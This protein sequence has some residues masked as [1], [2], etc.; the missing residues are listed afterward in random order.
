MSDHTETIESIPQDKI[1]QALTELE[2]HIENL[3]EIDLDGD[4]HIDLW[5]FQQAVRSPQARAVP[6]QSEIRRAFDFTANGRDSIDRQHISTALNSLSL[7]RK[8]AQ[9]VVTYFEKGA[10]ADDQ[11]RFE[12]FNQAILSVSP[13]P[14]EHEVLRVFRA[15][16]IQVSFLHIPEPK[17]AGA[18]REATGQFV[19]TQQLQSFARII[20]LNFRGRTTYSAFKCI[21]RMPSPPEIWAK[22]LPLARLLANALPKRA[23][24]DEMRLVSR[25]TSREI[26]IISESVGAALKGV[27][28]KHI[29]E[30]RKT[31][32]DMDKFVSKAGAEPNPL[33][34]FGLPE[35]VHKAEAGVVEHF[36]QGL[37]ARIGADPVIWLALIHMPCHTSPMNHQAH[38]RFVNS[39]LTA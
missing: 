35:T 34:K 11:I 18:L 31:Y 4:G 39:Q 26:D 6:Q 9:N 17:L 37:E 22:T 36:F 28:T 32:E 7:K 27:L 23:S 5:E 33:G 16:A 29:L 8:A 2:I 3:A 19:T 21:A 20:E 30:L 15:Y 1:C 25:L 38:S 24:D 10:L 12:E 13:L 14:D